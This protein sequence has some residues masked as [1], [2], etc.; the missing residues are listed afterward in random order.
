MALYDNFTSYVERSAFKN[1]VI[2][3]VN[4]DSIDITIDGVDWDD[5][6]WR[7]HCQGGYIP[8]SP[9]IP[10]SAGQTV[11]VEWD[12]FGGKP[13]AV[14]GFP[15]GARSC[16][17]LAL[18]IH[19]SL[20][21][22]TLRAYKL[23]A[24]INGDPI[25][26]SFWETTGNPIDPPRNYRIILNDI[27]MAYAALDSYPGT[28][29]KILDI[30]FAKNYPYRIGVLVDREESP[31]ADEDDEMD[32][33]YLVLTYR[34]DPATLEM[35]L[36]NYWGIQVGLVGCKGGCSGTNLEKNNPWCPDWRC[37][38]GDDAVRSG[39]F[40]CSA[41]WHY[42]R[43]SY[44]EIYNRDDYWTEDST[45]E[46]SA[47][48]SCGNTCCGDCHQTYGPSKIY[49]EETGEPTIFATGRRTA[50]VMVMPAGSRTRS[51]VYY[52]PTSWVYLATGETGH[53]GIIRYRDYTWSYTVTQVERCFKA[54]ERYQYHIY[55]HHLSSGEWPF[56]HV[57]DSGW[58][59]PQYGVGNCY[60]HVNKQIQANL[61][62]ANP[63]AF[64][65]NYAHNLIGDHYT[66]I[67]YIELTS[68]S[69]VAGDP[70]YHP[71]CG[72]PLGQLCPVC[73]PNWMAW[74]TISLVL[75]SDSYIYSGYEKLQKA[76]CNSEVT[77]DKYKGHLFNMTNPTIDGISPKWS[78][79]IDRPNAAL[80][81]GRSTLL[82]P[83]YKSYTTAFT[84]S[85]QEVRCKSGQTN[86]D[87]YD[88]VTVDD[89]NNEDFEYDAGELGEEKKWH[90]LISP[91]K[92]GFII[93]VTR[94]GTFDYSY[95]IYGFT[96][97]V[98]TAHGSG[99]IQHSGNPVFRGGYQSTYLEP[100]GHAVCVYTP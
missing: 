62:R 83:L 92:A 14:V 46:S 50:H 69:Q 49:L 94:E 45:S 38:C 21:P 41:H 98:E 7:Y 82:S 35:S 96:D 65:C 39:C 25:K 8:L 28:Y 64:K 33:H 67:P 34:I 79:H 58:G 37:G 88:P 24:W 47:S 87:C 53:A 20:V 9:K 12:Q 52:N 84:G 18:L 89:V 22:P 66:R 11:V 73:S 40:Q 100:K 56:D 75:A 80:V 76:D 55:G 1:A 3:N 81:W 70:S 29:G 42:E 2:R 74:Y 95:E 85:L 5:V 71:T 77:D 93:G 61:V 31:Y 78:L 44:V 91:A 51:S 15:D 27:A 43:V 26:V 13:L 6:D 30:Q 90:L 63:D 54:Q 57:Y 72:A 99:I 97:L 68:W 60:N 36:E 4:E 48:G 19:T 17:S 16:T 10:Y 32:Y 23:E 86:P 59:E